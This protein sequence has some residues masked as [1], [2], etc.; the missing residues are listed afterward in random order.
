MANA[1]SLLNNFDA[2]LYSPDF[3]SISKALTYKQN[4]LDSNRAALDL[5]YEKLTDLDIL[6]E[7][8]KDYADKRISAVTKLVNQ[9]ANQDL[10]NDGLARSLQKDLGLILDDNVKNAVYSTAVYRS[11]EATWKKLKADSPEKYADANYWYAHKGFNSY[12]NDGKVGSKYGGGG[13]VIEYSDVAASINANLPKMLKDKGIN[14][15]MNDYGNYYWDKTKTQDI[16]DADVMSAI[17]AS[18]NDKDRQQLQISANYSFKDYSDKDIKGMYK[19]NRDL[20][21]KEVNAEIKQINVGLAS[22]ALTPNAKAY[23]EARKGE[24]EGYRGSLSTSKIPSRTS[25][26]NSVYNE[27]FFR[28]FKNTYS[29]HAVL[30][31]NRVEDKLSFKELQYTMDLGKIAIQHENAMELQTLKNI[32]KKKSKSGSGTGSYEGGSVT[33]G[34]VG[35]P[36]RIVENSPTSGLD[37]VKPHYS[38][39]QDEVDDIARSLQKDGI[40]PDIFSNTDEARIA[41]EQIANFDGVSRGTSADGT[42]QIYVT[43]WKD[44][45]PVTKEMTPKQAEDMLSLSKS[46]KVL[47]DTEK[48]MYDELNAEIKRYGDELLLADDIKLE[49][50]LGFTMRVKNLDNGKQKLVPVGSEDKFK[51]SNLIKKAKKDISKL[52]S[53]ELATLE[54]YNGLDMMG[55]FGEEDDEVATDAAGH[56]LNQTSRK[57]VNG[58][59]FISQNPRDYNPYRS[60]SV[61]QIAVTDEELKGRKNV[62]NKVATSYGMWESIWQ[63][64][65][66]VV[67]TTN[68]YINPAANPIGA[69]NVWSGTPQ[70]ERGD[71]Y[72]KGIQT[73]EAKTAY[74]KIMDEFYEGENMMIYNEKYESVMVD[75]NV[76]KLIEDMLESGDDISTYNFSDADKM[77]IYK[78]NSGGVGREFNHLWGT[79]TDTNAQD[80]LSGDLEDHST[81]KSYEG[82][83]TRSNRITESLTTLSDN[84]SNDYQLTQQKGLVYNSDSEAG[85]VVMPEIASYLLEYQEKQVDFGD[86]IHLSYKT[87]GDVVVYGEIFDKDAEVKWVSKE[88]GYVIDKNNIPSAIP[89][90]DTQE[91][92]LFDV[93]RKEPD[94]RRAWLDTEQ[95]VPTMVEMVIANDAEGVI[96][97]ADFTSFVNDISKAGMQFSFEP[98]GNNY[99]STI[100]VRGFEPTGD[101]E[102]FAPM[103]ILLENTRLTKLQ[104]K[105]AGSVEEFMELGSDFDKLLKIYPEQ[106]MNGLLELYILKLTTEEAQLIK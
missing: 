93:A 66:D 29:K 1:Y 103:T 53:E 4:K 28:P 62:G 65:K 78:A 91:T 58:G 51:Y 74:D 52:S 55:G 46:F 37:E 21:I 18:L 24:L 7:Q 50:V 14:V 95:Y 81:G 76:R 83:E 22:N 67:N 43:G 73:E 40:L 70:H 11:E 68:A 34:G 99:A 59:Q 63:T 19:N 57:F 97:E 92:T 41:V 42:K 39:L 72:K 9:Y 85:E 44:G 89:Q 82:W 98:N 96:D 10:S 12:M 20:K 75:G 69:A 80:F 77:L 35:L 100:K 33:E 106:L 36:D 102:G 30:D 94:V 54:L 32:A 26:E 56:W 23:Y 90:S 45:K 84:L 64:T 6:K 48:L 47:G 88:D 49:N 31:I 79:D 87:N 16:S 71:I 86:N 61:Q 5:M 25:I 105:G 60:G 2:P 3:Q 101:D 27:N 17:K 15:K 38:Q 8:D 104:E 13:G